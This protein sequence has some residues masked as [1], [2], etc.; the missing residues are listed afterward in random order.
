MVKN[1]PANAEDAR[2]LGLV[3]GLGRSPG[4]GNGNPIFLPGKFHGQRSQVVT[5]HGVTESQ[6]SLSVSTS[7]KNPSVDSFKTTG[8]GIPA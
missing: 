3:S 1:L 2:E 6:T 8:S 7:M 4:R 5:V